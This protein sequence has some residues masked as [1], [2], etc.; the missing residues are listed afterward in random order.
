MAGLGKMHWL[1]V[2][3]LGLP[4]H[5]GL[6]WWT[7]TQNPPQKVN[8]VTHWMRLLYY[9][10]NFLRIWPVNMSICPLYLPWAE[11]NKLTNERTDKR[12]PKSNTKLT[13]NERTTNDGTN[14]QT[15]RHPFF[16]CCLI[17]LIFR[18]LGLGASSMMARAGGILAPYFVL[19][20]ST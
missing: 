16:Q 13:K 8:D 12:T 17:S 1:Q 3:P 20:V 2:S 14:W 15:A 10:S 4:V 18:N 11:P 9:K 19:L 6:T 5:F 7:P